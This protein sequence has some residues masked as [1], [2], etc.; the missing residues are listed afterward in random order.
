MLAL[1]SGRLQ[2][3]GVRVF[4]KSVVQVRAA[5][6]TSTHF[7][8]ERNYHKA[9]A[10]Q[11]ALMVKNPSASEGDV[12]DVGSIS[13]SG[14]SPGGGHG[15]PLQYSCLKNPTEEPGGLQSV[16]LQRVRHSL[17]TTKQ[18]NNNKYYT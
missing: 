10:S 18:Q 15:N 2:D 7:L 13:G 3:L 12:R 6:V 14:R 16:G 11:V 17:A 4:L 5:I 1:S 9:R 8:M